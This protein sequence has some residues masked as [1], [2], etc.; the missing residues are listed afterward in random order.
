MQ[1]VQDLSPI[2][3]RQSVKALRFQC[4]ALAA[5]ISKCRCVALNDSRHLQMSTPK[6]SSELKSQLR[7]RADGGWK[8]VHWELV[9]RPTLRQLQLLRGRDW[10]HES[11]CAPPIPPPPLYVEEG[12]QHCIL[13][14]WV[15]HFLLQEHIR[16]ALCTR[17]PETHASNSYPGAVSGLWTG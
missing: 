17:R 16:L 1:A 6:V 11:A 3:P 2:T 7:Q 8:R 9:E 15:C 10:C 14:A 13:T 12:R 5:K 4:M